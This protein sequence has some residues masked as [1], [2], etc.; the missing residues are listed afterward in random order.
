MGLGGA[1]PQKLNSFGNFCAYYCV[2]KLLQYTQG[3]W[4]VEL[5]FIYV[6]CYLTDANTQIIIMTPYM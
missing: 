2:Q 6:I 1:C 5:Q 3:M 4:C